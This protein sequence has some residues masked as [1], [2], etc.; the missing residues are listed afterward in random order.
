MNSCQS[1]SRGGTVDQTVEPASGLEL[2]IPEADTERALSGLMCL[3]MSC[4]LLLT[5]EVSI[6]ISSELGLAGISNGIAVHTDVGQIPDALSSQT[7]LPT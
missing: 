2:G 5:Q 3:P 1:S 7:G 4:D 6:S